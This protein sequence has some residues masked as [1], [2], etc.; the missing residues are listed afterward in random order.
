MAITHNWSEILDTKIYDAFLANRIRGERIGVVED[1]AESGLAHIFF[2]GDTAFKLYKTY[3]DKDHFIRGVFAPTQARKH[4]VE[5]DF[6]V[7]RH[8][9]QGIYRKMYSVYLL[10]DHVEITP[11]DES[12]IHVL[13]EMD[14]LDFEQNLHEQLLRN[15]L[16]ESG[17]HR[18]GYETARLTDECEVT[19]HKDIDWYSAA[20]DRVRFLRQ[21]VEWLPEDLWKEVEA[22]NSLEALEGHLE[23]NKANY[24]NLSGDLLSVNLDNHDENIFLSDQKVQII[25]V[26]PPMDCWWHG[27]AVANLTSIMVNIEALHSDDA[28]QKV[29]K[30]YE[31]YHGVIVDQEDP[32]FVF[33]KAFDYLISVAHFG[34]MSEKRD[35]TEKY[36]AKCHEIPS[37]FNQR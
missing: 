33:N 15:E 14:K 6:A 3:A 32:L 34:S 19:I 21:F 17:L 16:D 28:A 2:V 30:G 23:N 5:R 22:T 7:N 10:D 1:T 27:P 9:S 31:E 29:R 35:V 37:W 20:K 25:D 4:F 36:L 13:Y 18:L 26:Q 11:Y 12:S 24:Q 8:F